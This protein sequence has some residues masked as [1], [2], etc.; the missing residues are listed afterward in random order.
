MVEY[1][2]SMKL[3]GDEKTVD[4]LI[5]ELCKLTEYEEVTSFYLREIKYQEREI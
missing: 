3:K 1:V 2:V 5:K 4:Y